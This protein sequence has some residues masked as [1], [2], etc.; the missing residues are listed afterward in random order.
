MKRLEKIAGAYRTFQFYGLLAS[1][2][3]CILM[4]ALGRY[5]GQMMHAASRVEPSAVV[6]QPCSAERGSDQP[7][8]FRD[9]SMFGHYRVELVQGPIAIVKVLIPG[10]REGTPF[11]VDGFP[12]GLKQGDLCSGQICHPPEI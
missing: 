7:V 5:E 1:P 12:A 4:L 8:A 2:I 6:C 9:L 11:Y 10:G 3:L